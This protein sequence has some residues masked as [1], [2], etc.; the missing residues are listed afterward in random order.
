MSCHDYDTIDTTEK[1]AAIL[2][3]Q[4]RFEEAEKLYRKLISIWKLSEDRTRRLWKLQ[5]LVTKLV[6]MLSHTGD[7]DAAIEIHEN[8]I[9]YWIS[10]RLWLDVDIDKAVKSLLALYHQYLAQFGS[11]RGELGSIL[12]LHRALELKC[13]KLIKAVLDSFPEFKITRD[14]K[15]AKGQTVLHLVSKSEIEDTI[16]FAE[17]LL[18]QGASLEARD[19]EG[20][21]P[22]FVAAY[23]GMV[24]MVNFFL[25]RGA[26]TAVE[27]Q[28]YGS[29][30]GIKVWWEVATPLHAAIFRGYNKIAM[31]ILNRISDINNFPAVEDALVCACI[32]GLYDVVAL[33]L[34]KGLAVNSRPLFDISFEFGRFSVMVDLALIGSLCGGHQYLSRFLLER[35]A[36]MESSNLESPTALWVAV[37]TERED[38]VEILLAEGANINGFQYS[39]GD[40]TYPET[41][42][43]HACRRGWISGVRQLIS[44][45]ADSNFEARKELGRT[46]LQAACEA[47]HGSIVRTLLRS[48]ANVN[49]SPA[50]RGGIT[51][52]QAACRGGYESLVTMLLKR[53]ADV[54]APPSPLEGLSAIEAAREYYREREEPPVIVEMLENAGAIG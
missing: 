4:E 5:D 53:G 51:A 50:H 7:Y 31:R 39:G 15:D 33:L 45:G 36:W 24:P 14:A 44:K 17:K 54:N 1:I 28:L 40:D 13:P 26:D 9:G 2:V 22:L 11:L 23:Y 20:R 34:D 18:E 29:E 6:T 38:L 16:D 25:D 42:L 32:R 10:R 48:G 47:G 35:G 37:E 27:A 41:S 52:L 43:Q 19:S 3:S 30:D 46:A 21:T 49:A 12:P 8:L